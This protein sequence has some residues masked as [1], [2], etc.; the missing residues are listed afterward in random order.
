MSVRCLK[1]N[2]FYLRTLFCAVRTIWG[3]SNCKIPLKMNISSSEN[4]KNTPAL[5][6]YSKVEHPFNY[7]HE[8]ENSLAKRGYFL[9]EILN[10]TPFLRF[11]QQKRSD[12]IK[13]LLILMTLLPQEKA[14]YKFNIFLYWFSS[15]KSNGFVR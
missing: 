3:S 9:R 7:L 14:F 4:A 10:L 1:F 8:A 15:I 5:F 11:F 12:C 6:L 2:I 13:S